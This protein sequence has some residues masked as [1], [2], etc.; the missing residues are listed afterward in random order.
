MVKNVYILSDCYYTKFHLK[1]QKKVFYK[2]MY[3]DTIHN[4]RYNWN[5]T[6]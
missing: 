6:Q 3:V 4:K 1:N 5:Y 2:H